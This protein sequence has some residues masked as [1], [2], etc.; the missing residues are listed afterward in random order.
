MI[1]S[2]FILT[3][4]QYIIYF[5]NKFIFFQTFTREFESAVS[6]EGPSILLFT[7]RNSF[8]RP[9]AMAH[10]LFCNS[11]QPSST[12]PKMFF[13]TQCG[14][15]APFL[16]NFSESSQAP[17]QLAWRPRGGEQSSPNPTQRKNIRKEALL[18]VFTMWL[19][20]L[21]SQAQWIAYWTHT[22]WP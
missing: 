19:A 4:G 8:A 10:F 12:Q 20:D 6:G 5:Q 14:N 18:S 13:W 1:L 2:I 21:A 16:W 3:S 11:L 17:L 22:F 9:C 7:F 15:A